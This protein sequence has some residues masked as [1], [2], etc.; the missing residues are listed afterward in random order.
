MKSQ[1]LFISFCLL[2]VIILN[3]C[4]DKNA[5]NAPA[6]EQPANEDATTQKAE[7]Q[8]ASQPSLSDSLRD[9]SD[10]LRKAMVLPRY[11]SSSLNG[12]TDAAHRLK[13]Q[14]ATFED[15]LAAMINE[16]DSTK[17]APLL[18]R[19]LTTRIKQI[20][21]MQEDIDF[22]VSKIKTGLP[23]MKAALVLADEEARKNIL[24]KAAI[25]N[26]PREKARLL[27]QSQQMA[28][29]AKLLVKNRPEAESERYLSWYNSKSG[30]V[31]EWNDF[32]G[33]AKRR[34][35]KLLLYSMIAGALDE[36]REYWRCSLEYLEESMAALEQCKRTLSSEIEAIDQFRRSRDS[37]A[38][39]R[40]G[41]LLIDQRRTEMSITETLGK[42]IRLPLTDMILM[43][44]PIALP[45]TR[46]IA[47]KHVLSDP[48]IDKLT[49][50]IPSLPSIKSLAPMPECLTRAEPLTLEEL[51]AG[52]GTQLIQM[53]IDEADTAIASIKYR[54]QNNTFHE[55]NG[56]K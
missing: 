30:F 5:G 18:G 3:G 25:T 13:T 40:P 34:C 56:K 7:T 14:R 12:L 1:T 41:R 6:S 55:T 47:D 36:S 26:W 52:K 29:E 11:R 50:S 53:L 48:V 19:Y 42:L 35:K 39:A 33:D 32:V 45:S 21:T 22:I 44:T 49:A 10:A 46:S 43:D 24:R 28:T 2:V 4:Q 54:S 9:L 20:K 37:G 38:S 16:S 51:A 15:E 17:M 8:P 31:L 27:A 23:K